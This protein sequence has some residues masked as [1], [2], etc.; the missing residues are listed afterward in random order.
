MQPEEE[1]SSSLKHQAPF[2]SLSHGWAGQPCWPWQLALFSSDHVALHSH[3]PAAWAGG[4]G[5]GGGGE[6]GG[7]DGGGGE[8][9][10]GDGGGGE[11]GGGSVYAEQHIHFFIELLL[12][13]VSLLKPQEGFP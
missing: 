8:G 4:E 1:A 7:G 3:S 12:V 11:G 13:D 6:G 5:E 10:G 9:G 2:E